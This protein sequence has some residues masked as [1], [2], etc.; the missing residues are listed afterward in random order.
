MNE[1]TTPYTS[2]FNSIGIRE[3]EFFIALLFVLS[4]SWNIYEWYLFYDYDYVTFG[5]FALIHWCS[6]VRSG[7][8]LRTTTHNSKCGH[9]HFCINADNIQWF[10]VLTH[11]HQINLPTKY[12]F[13]DLRKLSA[14]LIIWKCYLWYFAAALMSYC[15]R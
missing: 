11:F 10:E 2:D 13:N 3:L 12:I 6:S 8:V 15:Q 14:G 7:R 1:H 4:V 9:G 5:T